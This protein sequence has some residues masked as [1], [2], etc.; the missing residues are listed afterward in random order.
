MDQKSGCEGQ[1]VLFEDFSRSRLLQRGGD[2]F[3]R[4]PAFRPPFPFSQ[5]LLFQAAY[6][7]WEQVIR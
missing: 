2:L 1:V 7:F 4:V 6:N 3:L 5:F